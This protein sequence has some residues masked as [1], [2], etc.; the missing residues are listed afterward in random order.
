[1]SRRTERAT[2]AV[3][4]CGTYHQL[5]MAQAVARLIRP[6][7][8]EVRVL[9]HGDR[10]LDTLD[11]LVLAGGIEP[12]DCAG[13]RR[14]K[15]WLPGGI[16]ELRP[17][18]ACIRRVLG[19]TP[20]RT[21][22]I[23]AGNDNQ[24]FFR[25]VLQETRARWRNVV[26]YEEGLGLYIGTRRYLEK[27]LVNLRLLRRP[28]LQLRFRDYSRNR[29]IRRVACNHPWLLQRTDVDVLPTADA[30]RCVA[31]TLAGHGGNENGGNGNGGPVEWLYVS[32]NFSEAGHV[33][34][35]EELGMVAGV[36]KALARR[37]RPSSIRIKF[38]PLDSPE[39]RE[40]IRAMGYEPLEQDEPLELDCLR[41][42]YGN[43][44]SFRSSALLNLALFDQ[45]ATRFWVIRS[46]RGGFRAL[47]PRRVARVFEALVKRDDRFTFFDPAA[48]E[49]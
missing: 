48:P 15:P 36:R 9:W 12:D 25:L 21:T 44:V 2:R 3:V 27:A 13:F 11:R 1:M 34:L 19:K 8:P 33:T 29:S 14:L 4:L 42:P 40:R 41:R 10:P 39:K 38:H 28:S 17:A 37:F 35:A 5:V 26:L 6:R 24:I 20:P 30:Y 47:Y 45:P 32:G 18:R 23:Y 31:S 49:E 22:D 7:Y 46:D 16:D 43:I